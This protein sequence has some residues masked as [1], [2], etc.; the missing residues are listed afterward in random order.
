MSA[1][2]KLAVHDVLVG[3]FRGFDERRTDDAFL[4][5]TFTAVWTSGD[6]PG[7]AAG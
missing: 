1:D 5:A 7:R 3:C 6:P 2:E 4:K